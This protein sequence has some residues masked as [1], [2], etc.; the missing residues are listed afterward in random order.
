M[1]WRLPAFTVVLLAA[2]TGCRGGGRLFAH[3]GCNNNCDCKQSCCTKKSCGNQCSCGTGSQ[4]NSCVQGVTTS[5]V[6]VVPSDASIMDDANDDGGPPPVVPQSPP[7]GSWP[8]P[9]K[10]GAN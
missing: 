6:P 8:P 9:T 3:R 7:K 5:D 4:S 2:L 1:C 10:R